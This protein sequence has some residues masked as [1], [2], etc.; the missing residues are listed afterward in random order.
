[1]NLKICMILGLLLLLQLSLCRENSSESHE[2][3]EKHEEKHKGRHDSAGKK[4]GSE[5]HEDNEKHEGKHKGRHD[6]VGK[7]DGSES[8]ED[9]KKHKGKHKGRHDSAGKKATTPETSSGMSG[10][11][12]TWGSGNYR[13]MDGKTHYVK[14][15]NQVSLLYHSHEENPEFI[16]NCQRDSGS[17]VNIQAKID[18]TETVINTSGIYVNNRKVDVPYTNGNIHMRNSGMYTQISSLRGVLTMTFNLKHGINIHLHKNYETSGIFGNSENVSA[19]NWQAF[20][21]KC[22]VH[23]GEGEVEVWFLPEN[24]SGKGKEYCDNIFQTYFHNMTDLKSACDHDYEL[25]DQEDARS[26]TCSTLI[27][28]AK[29][30]GN[31]GCSE[32]TRFWREDTDVVCDKPICSETQTFSECAPQLQPTCSNPNPVHEKEVIADCTCPNGLMLDDIGESKKCV[33]I[34][35]CPC[36]YDKIYQPNEKRNGSCNSECFCTGGKWI[37]SDENCPGTCKVTHGLDVVT[38][39]GMEYSLSGN[40]QYTIFQIAGLIILGQIETPNAQSTSSLSSITINM[41]VEDDEH[42]FVISKDGSFRDMDVAYHMSEYLYVKRHSHGIYANIVDGVELFVQS[43]PTMQVYISMPFENTDRN[44][45]GLKKAKSRVARSAVQGDQSDSNHNFLPAGLCG[46][47]NKNSKDDFRSSNGIIESSSTT[48]VDSWSQNICP[49][50]EQTTC[51]NLE[52]ETFAEEHCSELKN[53]SGVFSKCHSYVDYETYYKR[54]VSSTCKSEDVWVGLCS[55]LENYVQACAEKGVL[56]HNWRN[57]NC[58]KECMNNQVLGFT[59]FSCFPSCAS[60]SKMCNKEGLLMEMCTCEEGLYLNSENICVPKEDCDCQHRYGVIPA[61][62]EIEIENTPCKCKAGE[63]ECNL[64]SRE[65]MCSGGAEYTQCTYPSTRGKADRYC[66]TMH[67]PTMHQDIICKPGC[68]CPDGMV[69]D[70]RG[71]CITPEDCSCLYEGAEYNSRSTIKNSCGTCT[72]TRGKWDCT[73]ENCESVCSIHGSGHYSTFDGMSYSFSGLCQY[74]IVEGEIEDTFRI[75]MQSEPCCEGGLT[76]SRRVI[77][78]TPEA[79]ITLQDGKA[80]IESS[81]DC[82]LKKIK[83]NHS[84]IDFG[85]HIIVEI[86]AGIR[87]TWDKKTDLTLKCSSRLAGKVRGLCGNNNYDKTDD[88]IGRNGNKFNN[89]VDLGD[90]YK[91]DPSCQDTEVKKSPCDANPNCKPWAL[92]K[93]QIMKEELFKECHSK[94]DPTVFYEKC[95]E[96]ACVC[97]MEGKYLGFC[98]SVAMYARS[99]LEKGV[100]VNWRNPDLCP[101]YC[102]FYNIYGENTWHYEPCGS[103][104]VQ[105]CGNQELFRSYSALLEGC[106]PRCPIDAPFLDQNSMKCVRLSDCSCSHNGRIMAANSVNVDECGRTCYCSKGHVIFQEE[107]K[108]TTKAPSVEGVKETTKAPSVEGEMETTKAP[109]VEGVK[110]TTKAPSVEGEMETTKAPSVEGEMETTKAPSVEGEMETTKAPSVEGVKETTKAPSVEG[111]METTKAPSVEGEMETTKAPSVEGEMETTKAPSVEGEMETTKAPSVEGVKETTK[112]PSVEGEKET[113]KAPFVEGEVDIVPIKEDKPPRD[114]Q[115]QQETT[116]APSV[117]GQQET[118]KAPSVEGQQETTKAPSVEGQQE[119]TKAPSVEGQQ[120]TTK[121]PSVEGEQ[122]TT[123]A[124]SVEGEQE[125]T[126]APSVEGVKETTKAPSVEA[127][128]QTTK[129][130]SAEGTQPSPSS[131]AGPSLGPPV[132]TRSTP[133]FTFGTPLPGPVLPARPT[134]DLSRYKIPTPSAIKPPKKGCC[135]PS[136][137]HLMHGEYWQKGCIRCTCNGK[138]GKME[139]GSYPCHEVVCGANETKVFEDPSKHPGK[140]CCG[141]CAPLTC[142]HNGREYKINASFSDPNDPCL[143]Y[144]CLKTGLTARVK[145]CPPQACTP[146]RRTYDSDKCC[147]TCDTTCKPTPAIITIE[148]PFTNVARTKMYKTC[149]AKASISSCT[150]QCDR[151]TRY[152]DQSRN[153]TVNCKCCQEEGHK[154]RS[155][156]LDCSDGSKE[157]HTFNDIASCACKSCGGLK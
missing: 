128:K 47:F 100:C 129:A 32:E 123:Q 50:A 42:T 116:K 56:L 62:T 7:K 125:T 44:S 153:V 93:C 2:D 21:R 17:L 45:L 77:L 87:L 154:K 99:C 78:Q 53:S 52:K 37:C 105:I 76:C 79:I 146:D 74:T 96:E 26:C 43:L 150:G 65:D 132:H 67:L 81:Q 55:A 124:P 98:S 51:I 36:F 41:K 156:Q 120:E 25:C 83:P 57:Q 72:C 95:I 66:K 20:A 70:S 16:I 75:S 31:N 33:N 1:M 34:D 135:G 137:G 88:F 139:C 119:T 86:G 110:E 151:S 48:F 142:K 94:V 130:P 29:I 152:D 133:A 111:E 144:T 118:T 4:D 22:I 10:H 101:M 114:K 6:S 115:G 13:M 97:D 112:A 63:M 12:S 122:E 127:E 27:Q 40:C 157:E 140:S 91:D 145:K 92:R 113:T 143:V 109:S 11:C 85:P 54:C 102:D 14:T 59:T 84:V 106:Y 138:T 8:H 61:H 103:A 117:E 9:N 89:A 68:Y 126:K 3:N 80:S 38:F 49:P 15:S 131:Q 5:S 121:A 64:E 73:E 60:T 108:E 46:S 58:K 71:N 24:L 155:V 141:Y 107:E 148:K 35:E 28:A 136:G 69:R 23:E 18:N 82:S 149:R 104:E 39:D 30:I 134:I 147:Y 19:E 90:S